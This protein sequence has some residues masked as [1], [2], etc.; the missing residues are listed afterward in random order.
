MIYLV[1]GGAG[2]IGAN[3]LNYIVPKQKD[4]IFINIDNLGYSGNL[5]NVENIES[6]ENYHF[7]NVDIQDYNGL[8]QVFSEWNPDVIIH[9]A[10]ESHVDRSILSPLHFMKTNILG[11][12]NLLELAR[13]FWKDK[14]HCL[15][16]HVST[17]EVYGSLK[18]SGYF[19]ETT[20]Y[21]PNSPYSASKASSDHL[22][23]AYY[24]T[25]DL[26]VTISNCSNN[27]GPYQFP[28]KLIPMT[29][30]NFLNGKPIPIYGS[31]QNIRDWLYV[32]DHC[33]AIWHIIHNSEVG[34]TYNVGGNNELTN[35]EVVRVIADNLSAFTGVDSSR[36]LEQI[37]YVKDRPG[38]DFRYAIDASKIKNTLGWSPEETIESGMKKTVKWYLDHK[39][40]I[41]KVSSGDYQ[42]WIKL[43][44]SN[45]E[46]GNR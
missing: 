9:F 40:W 6:H 32:V 33:Q 37:T 14:E 2:F 29:L 41:E 38:H 35:L 19:T 12:F 39:D 15:F 21:H 1:T 7:R 20:P 45:R 5:L 28:E 26:P 16:H 44:Y 22:V 31:G 4:D 34:E 46:V 10:A 17:D 42:G 43:N 8:K 23:R 3:F 13:N 11:T 27:Y 25:Y 36:Y 30:S 24:H 18:E